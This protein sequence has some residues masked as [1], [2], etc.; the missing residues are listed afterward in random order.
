MPQP[1]PQFVVEDAADLTVATWRFL[2]RETAELK[3]PLL[4]P[5]Q[6]IVEFLEEA[7]RKR[8]PLKDRIAIVEQAE[9]LF[10]HLYPHLPFK[11]ETFHLEH[12]RQY[13][14]KARAG[15]P[16]DHEAAFQGAMIEAFSRVQD[17]HTTYA[18][19]PPWRGA[20]AFLP[21]QIKTILNNEPPFN[22]RYFVSRVMKQSADEPFAHKLFG[23]G[24]EIVG[25][26]ATP[27]EE[28][29]RAVADWLPGGNAAALHARGALASTLRPLTSVHPPFVTE[30]AGADIR[31][32][33][34]GRSETRAIRMP[35]GVA[36]FKSA[37]A[38]PGSTFSVSSIHEDYNTG[39]K[40]QYR[41][42][43]RFE[44]RNANWN[45]PRA[46]S[47]IPEVFEFQ[48]TGGPNT[49]YPIDINILSPPGQGEP[50]RFG[51]LRIKAFRDNGKPFG[52]ADRLVDEARRILTLLDQQ[53]PDGLI[54]DIR[55]NPGGEI[56]A[57]ERI[58]QLLTAAEIEPQVFHYANT[59][60]V[61]NALRRVRA[62]QA[63]PTALVEFELSAADAG[64]TPISKS[65]KIEDRLTT[66]VPI[67]NPATANGI[68]Q[69]YHGPVTLLTDAFTYSAADI[70]AAGFQDHLI[71]FMLGADQFT[72]G[73]GAN[74]WNHGDLVKKLGPDLGIPLEPLPEGV[75][76]RLAFRRCSRKGFSKGEP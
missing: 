5:V 37:P 72:G 41:D 59:E 23:P 66:G 32:I 55:G 47:T 60:A 1:A 43:M 2:E 22:N 44:Q 30:F 50:P 31:Y 56:K 45:D 40:M 9:L 8:T 71:G 62:G 65:D 52:M 67:T 18:C 4:G 61:Q 26:G 10:D 69:A 34:K 54:V 73:G 49:D 76:M 13:L 24:A 53:A 14:E 48:F 27:I 11:L 64:R 46:V 15:A 42:A 57:A 70:F 51:Y 75:G 19:P 74:V 36:R 68:R 33:P 21:F 39:L 29:V 58:L 35:W 28:Y 20:I 7:N 12:P 25:W 6:P 63:S 3:T 17:A 16:S 38:I